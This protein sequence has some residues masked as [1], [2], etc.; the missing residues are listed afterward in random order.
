MGS[1]DQ[2]SIAWVTF[3]AGFPL[4]LGPLARGGRNGPEVEGFLPHSPFRFPLRLIPGCGPAPRG[5]VWGCPGIR[6]KG[7][8]KALHGSRRE[9]GR[10]SEAPLGPVL[11]RQHWGVCC[12]PSGICCLDVKLSGPSAHPRSCPD[13]HQATGRGSLV[14]RPRSRL[15]LSGSVS[16]REA[17]SLN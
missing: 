10:P 4:A 14:G 16:D 11:Q 9:Q 7:H 5:L 6:I 17:R 12:C 2:C 13:L 15:P 8:P 3:L 1:L